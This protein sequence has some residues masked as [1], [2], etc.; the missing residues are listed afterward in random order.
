LLIYLLFRIGQIRE[1][2]KAEKHNKNFL[3]KKNFTT[4]CFKMCYNLIWNVRDSI[5]GVRM[6]KISL[7]IKLTLKYTGCIFVATGI[8]LFLATVISGTDAQSAKAMAKVVLPI[9]F[10]AS[11]AIGYFLVREVLKRTAD[12]AESAAEI[13]RTK[14]FSRQ[15]ELE[16]SDAELERLQLTLNELLED[17]REEGHF[18]ENVVQEMWMP[19][20]V[21]LT[22]SAW[23]L[24]DWRLSQR[25]RWQIEL[26]QK[27]AQI[28]S[29]FIQE[30]SFFAKADQG[31][32]PA[33]KKRMNISE[34]T[35]GIIEGQISRL[36]EADEPVQIDYEI[37]PEI[38]AEVDENC[39]RKM[40]LNLL[41]NS[42]DYSREIGLIKVVVESKGSEFTC[43]IA[44]AGIGISETDLPHVW[45]RFFRGDPLGAGEGHFGLGLSVVKWIAEVHDGWVDA[46]SILGSGSCFTVGMPCEPKPE[47]EEV[48]EEEKTVDALLEGINGTDEIEEEKDADLTTEAEGA[49]ETDATTEEAE[50]DVTSEIN[51]TAETEGITEINTATETE[52][53]TENRDSSEESEAL[54]ET[55]AMPVI[56]EDTEE[57]SSENFVPDAEKD[58]TDV[59]GENSFRKIKICLSKI[60]SF[61]EEEDDEEDSD[62]DEEALN[63]CEVIPF[64]SKEDSDEK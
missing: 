46:E 38:Y 50:T 31:C 10:I 30:V 17:V 56:T 63:E 32:Q 27:K 44:D 45:D 36:Q 41:E 26:V 51:E 2:Y 16:E 20:S 3:F 54:G 11:L 6:K 4:Y 9:V 48:S 61:L 35:T 49:V 21:I 43:K 5:G 39:Y 29:D 14:D 34:L 12:L 57:E 18:A 8:A 33:Y 28:L 15:L 52:A 59:K 62:E 37:E 23:C 64:K 7:K 47:A 55:I 42:I 58:E 1:K 24:G 53:V 13:C 60:K 19:V 22:R 40:L 25:Q